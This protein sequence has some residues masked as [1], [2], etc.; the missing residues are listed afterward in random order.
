MS[1]LWEAHQLL[2]IKGKA[3]DEFWLVCRLADQ[4]V[5]SL[6][7][8]LV[9]DFSCGEA[10]RSVALGGGGKKSNLAQ[11]TFTNAHYSARVNFS[12]QLLP[13]E[14]PQFEFNLAARPGFAH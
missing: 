8:M 3:A 11:A 12:N 14:R 2:P 5:P 9:T 1:A 10:L 4:A 7:S 6:I 13:F